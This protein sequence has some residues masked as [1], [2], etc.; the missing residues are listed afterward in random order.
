MGGCSWRR[1]CGTSC[2]GRCGTM[3][4]VGNALNCLAVG[5]HVLVGHAERD[6][7]HEPIILWPGEGSIYAVLTS[8]NDIYVEQLSGDQQEVHAFQA[9]GCLPRGLALPA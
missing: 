9:N 8:D 7:T 1:G 2:R 6:V 5:V 3:R 4:I